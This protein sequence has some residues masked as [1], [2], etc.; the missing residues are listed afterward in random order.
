[1]TRVVIETVDG[2]PES[3]TLVNRSESM[4]MAPSGDQ[5]YLKADGLDESWYAPVASRADVEENPSDD[6]GFW[7]NQYLL[8]S[9]TFPIRGGLWSQSSSL[10]QAAAR[11]KLARLHNRPLQ[12]LVEDEL[13]P[14]WV[15][16][17]SRQAPVIK[18][19]TIYRVEFTLFITCPDPVK[20]GA[21]AR[22][23]VTGNTVTV[24]NGGDYP[25]WPMIYAAGP[26]TELGVGFDGHALAWAGSSASGVTIDP[27]TG[28]V[29]DGSG[30]EIGGIQVD[31]VFRIPPGAH[32]LA[33][34]ADA[35]VSVGVRPGW[36]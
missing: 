9:R 36:L 16:G 13:G 5:W 23:P 18:R 32:E 10:G 20:V 2:R 12:V 34:T 8:G 14:R 31:D 3:L 24:E 22:Y 19:P 35:D 11:T 26:V 17:F 21:E 6:G 27:Q 15:R 30:V 33:V 4:D 29:T 25:T 28:I 1:M 7:P